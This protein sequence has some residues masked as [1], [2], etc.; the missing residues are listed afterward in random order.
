MY[1][2]HLILRAEILTYHFHLTTNTWN[3]LT[4][5][6]VQVGCLFAFIC[7]CLQVCVL[8]LQRSLQCW[9]E[10]SNNRLG[11]D[12]PLHWAH[13]YKSSHMFSFGTLHFIGLY[14]N[15][16]FGLVGAYIRYTRCGI[17]FNMCLKKET[18]RNKNTGWKKLGK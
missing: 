9:W 8:S 10:L 6:V 2:S 7:W 4:G 3:R 1:V 13:R 11:K 15:N 5:S 17:P 16:G 14:F 12:F 18:I